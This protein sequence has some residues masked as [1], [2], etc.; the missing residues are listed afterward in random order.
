MPQ[1]HEMKNDFVN[2]C[3]GFKSPEKKIRIFLVGKPKME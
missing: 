1:W 2:V 3:M